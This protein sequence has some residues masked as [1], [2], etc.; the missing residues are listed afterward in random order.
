MKVTASSTLAAVA[1][2]VSDALSKAGIRAVLTGGACATIYSQSEYQSANID[3]ILQSVSSQ[4]GLDRAMASAGFRRDRDHYVHPETDFFVEFPRGPLTI[5]QDFQIEPRKL[6]IGSSEIEALSATDSC[7]DRL[8]AYYFWKDRQ[9]LDAAVSIA[10]RNRI[11]LATVRRWSEQEGMLDRYREFMKELR[12]VR[13]R[14]R[15]RLGRK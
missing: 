14:A 8:A 10:R 2:K 15:N 4:R 5:G 12:A 7:R 11:N 1:A 3:L 6:K 13:V 9:A